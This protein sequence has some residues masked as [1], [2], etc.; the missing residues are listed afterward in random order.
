M[1]RAAAKNHANV[2]I[3]TDPADYEAVLAAIGEPVASRSHSAAAWPWQPSDTPRRTTRG[4][5]LELSERLE[6]APDGGLPAHLDLSLDR[7]L[8]LRLRREPAS[9]GG[10][11]PAAGRD[12]ATGPFARGVD[13]GGKAL[14]YN[15]L[16]DAAA[17]AA[18]ARDLHGAACTI[19]NMPIRAV[20]Q[21]PGMP[22]RPGKA[23]WRAIRSARSVASP[24]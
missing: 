3:V 20:R 1:V 16:L 11:V 6:P 23:R 12:P 10:D 8:E 18:I 19:V 9:V 21:R 7:S 2:G 24:R 17:A 15:N 22:S 5:Q 13:V 14:S 4:S